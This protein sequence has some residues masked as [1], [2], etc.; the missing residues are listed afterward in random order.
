MKMLIFVALCTVIAF[1][2]SGC[3]SQMATDNGGYPWMHR[4]PSPWPHGPPMPHFRP[5][6]R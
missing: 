2:A 4:D 3:A 1:A 6:R 5:H